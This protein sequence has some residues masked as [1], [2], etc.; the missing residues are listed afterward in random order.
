MKNSNKNLPSDPL[1]GI[2]INELGDNLGIL[3][4]GWKFLWILNY[5]LFEKDS[6]GNP[7]GDNAPI[8]DWPAEL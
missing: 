6:D 1:T 3:N 2:S 7:T 4:H 5:P 8:N